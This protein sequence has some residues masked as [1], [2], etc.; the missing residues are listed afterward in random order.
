MVF[1]IVLNGYVFILNSQFSTWPTPAIW[2]FHNV[3]ILAHPTV[4]VRTQKFLVIGWLI[5]D[6]FRINFF[7]HGGRQ[8]ATWNCEPEQTLI[9]LILCCPS[10]RFSNKISSQSVKRFRAYFDL[11]ISKMP[12]AAISKRANVWLPIPS[13]VAICTRTKNVVSTALTVA[14]TLRLMFFFN[15]HPNFLR[16][17]NINIS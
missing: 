13:V 3:L 17:L 5:A 6:I 15:R 11:S 12:A 2:Y 14:Y 9:F 4:F 1:R 7:Q 10:M 8:V 16:L